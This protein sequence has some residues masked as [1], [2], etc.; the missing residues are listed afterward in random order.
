MNTTI[1]KLVVIVP[2]LILGFFYLRDHYS[3]LAKHVSAGR[4]LLMWLSFFLLYAWIFIET[5]RKKQASIISTGIQSSFFVYVFM[6]LTLTGYFILFREFSVHN[7]YDKMMLRVEKKDHVNLELFKIFSIYKFSNKQVIGNFVMLLPL[8][9]YLPLIYRR[10][11]NVLIVL[12]VCMLVSVIIE[13]MQLITKYRSAD[14]D[15]VMLNTAGALVGYG[16]FWI[17]SGKADVKRVDKLT[18][19]TS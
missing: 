14:I 15:D 10:M 11:S 16:L 1:K 8:G 9:I 3:A 18:E 7:W 2:V 5:I 13:L 12:L 6:V 4:V 19:L 17:F